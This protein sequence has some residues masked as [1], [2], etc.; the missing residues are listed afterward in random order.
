[1]KFAEMMK[2]DSPK[3]LS[4]RQYGKSLINSTLAVS[5]HVKQLAISLEKEGKKELA[6]KLE[7]VFNI[8]QRIAKKWKIKDTIA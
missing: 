3:E 7:E 4:K 2:H 8:L 5:G 6:N 1:M